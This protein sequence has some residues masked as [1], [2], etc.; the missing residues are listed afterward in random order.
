MSLTK[1]NAF[2]YG[3]MLK[4]KAPEYLD[5]LTAETEEEFETAFD[6]LLEKALMHLEANK[7]NFETLN[8]EGL[9]AALAG[10][11][12]IPGLTVSQEKNSGGH[13]DLTFEADHCK[14]ARTILG[15]AKIYKGYKY[16][17][18][19]LVQLLGRY[20]TGRECRSLLIVY[21]RKKDIKSLFEKLRTEMDGNLPLAQKKATANHT[22]KWS[23]L[24]I[25]THNCG[26]DLTVCHVGCNLHVG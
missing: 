23:F 18:G 5:L 21:V 17:E 24:S 4:R 9:S 12:S 26:E 16:H 3:E 22:L 20:I 7:K 11:M 14:P 13:V 6:V 10:K 8:E 1:G 25:H 15:E 19:G 2:D